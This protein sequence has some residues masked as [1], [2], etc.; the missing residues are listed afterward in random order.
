MEDQHIACANDNRQVLDHVVADL[1]ESGPW[2]FKCHYYSDEEVIRNVLGRDFGLLCPRSAL[3]L[4][5]IEERWKEKRGPSDEPIF[6]E[7]ASFGLTPVAFLMSPELADRTAVLERPF[8]WRSL[9]DLI[10]NE[11]SIRIKRAA[12]TNTDGTAVSIAQHEALRQHWGKNEEPELVG[13]LVRVLERHVEE[14]GPSDEDVLRRAAPEGKWTADLVIAQERSIIAAARSNLELR[15]TIAYPHDGTLEVP[16]VAARIAEWRRPGT[17]EAF[18]EL[19]R[20]LSAVTDTELRSSGL[21]AM[22]QELASEGS[23][24]EFA[25]GQS[26]AVQGRLSWAPH[27][28]TMP[29]VLPARR[30]V[31]GIQDLAEAAKRGVDVCLLFDASGSMGQANKLAEAAEGVNAFLQMLQGS[32]S[33]ACLI[34]FQNRPNVYSPLGPNFRA[35]YALGSLSA[36]GETALLDA[37][38]LGIR[39]LEDSGQPSHIWAIVGFTDGL[40][41]ASVIRVEDVVQKLIASRRIRFY[42]IAYGSDADF[43]TL[44]AMASAAEGFV[45]RGDPGKIRAVYERISTYV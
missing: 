41:N 45:V 43:T 6:G 39:T 14:Y 28:G 10:Q 25:A 33:R 4:Q 27:A 1:N 37:V 29:L 23:I 31:R 22:G 9:I 34:T 32:S 5:K 21:H 13:Q 44:S 16:I 15:G 3:S 18:Q 36:G 30:S 20:R 11:Q 8:G 19:S 35:G 38:D 24:K 2:R 26:A 40:E 17:E 7:Q 42:G 12:F